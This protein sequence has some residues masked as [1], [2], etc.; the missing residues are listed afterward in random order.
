MPA[1][2]TQDLGLPTMPP[3]GY[4]R[5]DPAVSLNVA[6]E[7]PRPAPPEARMAAAVFGRPGRSSVQT[8][9]PARLRGRQSHRWPGRGPNPPGDDGHRPPNAL[10]PAAPRAVPRVMTTGSVTSCRVGLPHFGLGA[11]G[12]E[13]V[14]HVPSMYQV[15]ARGGALAETVLVVI[16]PE[17]CRCRL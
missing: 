12:H 4:R 7:V 10:G 17:G 14:F 13:P 11:V 6:L 16:I 5:G 2:L 15:Q 1:L 9:Q 3:I 8:A